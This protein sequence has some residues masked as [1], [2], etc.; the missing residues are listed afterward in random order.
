MQFKSVAVIGCGG[1]ARVAIAALRSSG[2]TVLACTSLAPE[3]VDRRFITCD[4]LTD[5]MLLDAYSPGEI[6]LV[7]GIGSVCPNG[8]DSKLQGVVNRFLSKGY[9]FTGFQHSSAW[10]ANESCVDPLAQIHAGAIVQP[11]ALVGS[12][13]IINTRASVDHDCRIGQF[14]HI[15][16]GVTLSGDVHIRDGTHIGTGSSV[17][18]GIRIGSNAFIAA[19]SV[20]VRDVPDNSYVRGVPA[21]SYSTL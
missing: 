11:G 21:K 20:V 19:G 12:F 7:L 4:V 15:A 17:I 2:K 6:D 3:K 16:P 8:P 10:V 14:C 13:S 1:H 18:Q 9:Q 5:E